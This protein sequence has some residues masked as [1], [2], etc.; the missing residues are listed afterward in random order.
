MCVWMQTKNEI[1]GGKE[2]NH[3]HPDKN[4]IQWKF[5]YGNGNIIFI[6]GMEIV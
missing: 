1:E 6:N 3:F 5:V 4:N 2:W